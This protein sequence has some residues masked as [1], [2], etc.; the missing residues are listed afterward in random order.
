[1][2]GK[3]ASIPQAVL[4]VVFLLGKRGG[5]GA[6]A[7]GW[8]G[9]LITEEE[10]KAK[11]EAEKEASTSR[12]GEDEAEDKDPDEDKGRKRRDRGEIMGRR[13]SDP[14]DRT[15]QLRWG[16]TPPRYEDTVTGPKRQKSSRED[17]KNTS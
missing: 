4:A 6:G 16:P 15:L 11:R 13:T 5:R 12:Q 10:A 7:C 1:M 2:K 3:K 14:A 8:G 9:Y 17:V